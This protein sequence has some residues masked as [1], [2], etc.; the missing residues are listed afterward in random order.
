V[1][2]FQRSKLW[3]RSF[4]FLTLVCATIASLFKLESSVAGELN[5]YGTERVITSVSVSAR[6]AVNP[7]SP[8]YG[9]QIVNSYPHDVNAFTQGLIFH[10]G[11]LYESTGIQGRSSL[12]KV[13]L[14][15]GSVL[16]KYL[17]PTRFFG[18]G[19][20]LWKDKLI[21]LTW[22]GGMGIVYD[23]KTF[24]P[25]YG[26]P[27]S[28]EGW[29]ITHDGR[30]LIMSDGSSTLYFLDPETFRQIKN[31]KI[32][33]GNV[34]VANLN[35]LEYVNGEIYAN[36]WLTDYIARIAPETGRVLGWIDL[37]ELLGEE[38]RTPSANV[39]NG[40]AYDK[41]QDRLFVTGKYWPK[42]FEIKVTKRLH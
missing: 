20:T 30:H 39:L 11:F 37:E 4:T 26:F 34:A 17:L 27:Y 19:L 35:E 25:L 32:H 28:T 31:I 9:Y 38:E 15:T 6:T 23:Q 12:R 14:E 2:K 7:N 33:D 42:L 22:H 21:Q 1:N 24:N 40:I 13:E 36:V 8:V 5:S 10:D 29:G 3:L 18:E 16:Q 41:Q